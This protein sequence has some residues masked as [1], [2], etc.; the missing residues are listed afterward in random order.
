MPNVQRKPKH[1]EPLQKMQ[2]IYLSTAHLNSTIQKGIF[3]TNGYFIC[4]P[5]ASYFSGT[6]IAINGT[7]NGHGILSIQKTHM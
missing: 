4:S 3:Y 7:A 1:I 6:I 2:C 5:I